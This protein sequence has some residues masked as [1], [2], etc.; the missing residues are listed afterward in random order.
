MSSLPLCN[1]MQI[2]KIVGRGAPREVRASCGPTDA[3]CI[4]APRKTGSRLP[5]VGMHEIGWYVSVRVGMPVLGH[6]IQARMLCQMT[7]AL[8]SSLPLFYTPVMSLS[9]KRDVNIGVHRVP[10]HAWP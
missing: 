10:L 6:H 8:Q 9:K 5:Q 3:L 4:T 1:H 7:S 2:D